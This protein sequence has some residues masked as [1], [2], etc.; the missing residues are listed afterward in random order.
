MSRWLALPAALLI[1]ALIL[2]W[3][4]AGDDSHADATPTAVATPQPPL[5]T[6]ATV[7]AKAPEPAKQPDPP[8]QPGKLDPGKL[9]P[10]G[11]EFFYRFVEQVPKRL[12]R[13]AAECYSHRTGT[14]HRNQK[15]VLAFNVKIRDGKVT[16][17]DVKIKDKDEDGNPANTLADPALESC[18]IQKVARAGW[19]DP[20]LPD[21]D[22]PDEQLVLRPERGMKK[23]WKSNTEYVGEPMPEK[24]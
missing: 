7:P 8:P 10:M 22:W 2:L 6:I 19:V 16:V 4:S 18:F 1:V 21:Y 14:L 3:R 12:T 13:E 11:D 9:D 20:E 23:Y 15:L 5:A 24:R 17:S